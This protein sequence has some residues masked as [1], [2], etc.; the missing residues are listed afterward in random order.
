MSKGIASFVVIL[1][2][3]MSIS[4]LAGIGFYDSLQVNYTGD[5]HNEDVQAAAD[6]MT[7]QESTTT[8]TN[9]IEDFTVGAGTTL[10]AAWQ[11]ISNTSGVL[12]LLFGLPQG[13][14]EA[15]QTFIRIIYGITFAGFIRG[16]AMG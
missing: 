8:G 13:V 11:V 16:V 3:I 4:V 5:Q 9:P 14:A 12:Q 2:V 6:A 7:N 15:M 10:S 1:A